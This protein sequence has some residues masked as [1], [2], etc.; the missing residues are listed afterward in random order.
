MIQSRE[1]DGSGLA[2]ELSCREEM[3]QKWGHFS[4]C[5]VMTPMDV[6][7]LSAPKACHAVSVSVGSITVCAR[8]ANI[9]KVNDE[10]ACLSLRRG[11]C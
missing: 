11:M 5:C 1:G 10:S 8:C 9:K 3:T 4:R 7:A 6:F 2:R